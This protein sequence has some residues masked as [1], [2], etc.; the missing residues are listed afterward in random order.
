MDREAWRATV[1]KVTQ[2]RTQLKRLSTHTDLINQT[3]TK[4]HQIYAMW[5]VR[6]EIFLSGLH[7]SF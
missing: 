6:K 4:L 2:N 5:M 3:M 7:G 1:R